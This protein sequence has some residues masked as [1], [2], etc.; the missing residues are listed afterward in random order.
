MIVARERTSNLD[1]WPCS[2]ALM[3]EGIKTYQ[4]SRNIAKK[5][6]P[7]PVLSLCRGRVGCSAHEQH[8]LVGGQGPGGVVHQ[9]LQPIHRGPQLAH[10]LHQLIGA[11]AHVG[12]G[13]V[14][15]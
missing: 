10:A 2:D 8:F 7:K 6:R 15:R 13:T 9:G 1:D 14:G 5:H 11:M 12:F 4:W 3:Q